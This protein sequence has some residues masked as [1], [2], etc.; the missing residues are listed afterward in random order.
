MRRIGCILVLFFVFTGCSFAQNIKTSSKTPTY[1]MHMVKFGETLTK[2]SKQYDVKVNEILIANP[3]LTINSIMPDQI[4]RI[5]NNHNKKLATDAKTTVNE[6]KPKE[7]TINIT[8]NAKTHIVQKGETLYSISKLYNVNI[9]DL[10]KWNS[11][12]E[13]NIGLGSTLLLQSPEKEEKSSIK[14]VKPDEPKDIQPVIAKIETQDLTK[15]ELNA[16]VQ[17]E[18]DIEIQ[19]TFNESQNDLSKKFKQIV[20]TIDIKGTGAPMTTTLGA[21]ET[22]YFAMHRTLSIG[23]VIKVKN[24]VNN[25]IVYA[26]VIGK[27]PDTDENRNIII[28]YTLGVKKDLQL[29]NGKCYIQI[30]IPD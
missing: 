16:V 5:P 7:K 23:S 21:M 1:I 15:D 19:A 24:L 27:L 12:E 18:D 22:V 13:N 9:D 14:L 28:R 4:I 20:K 30:T 8:K 26:K 3:S 11:I 29:Q 2:I 10:I 25:K 17:D 6:L